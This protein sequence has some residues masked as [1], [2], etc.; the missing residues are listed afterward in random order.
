MRHELLFS[1]EILT[2]STYLPFFFAF[3]SITT[4]SSSPLLPVLYSYGGNTGAWE[5]SFIPWQTKKT[6]DR[7]ME[8]PCS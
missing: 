6:D 5:Q 2:S 7:E 4:I 8:S 3:F 1:I